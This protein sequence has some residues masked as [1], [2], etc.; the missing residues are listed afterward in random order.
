MTPYVTRL[1]RKTK[2]EPQKC[3]PTKAP[4]GPTPCCAIAVRRSSAP[5]L[6]PQAPRSMVRATP[7]PAALSAALGCSVLQ[8]ERSKYLRAPISGA[9]ALVVEHR[10]ERGDR[11]FFEWQLGNRPRTDGHVAYGQLP[12][13]EVVFM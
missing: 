6:A 7:P 4:A 12:T 11:V 8:E 10:S 3:R 2:T 1:I 9:S 5:P 13:G